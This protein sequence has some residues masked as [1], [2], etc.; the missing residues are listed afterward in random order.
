[1]RKRENTCPASAHRDSNFELLRIIAMVLIVAHHYVV[2]SGLNFADGPIWQAP[3]TVRSLFLLLYGAWGKTAI[4]CFVLITGYFMCKSRITV[5][6]YLKLLL[7]VEFYNLLFYFLFCI[8]GYTEFSL[9]SFAKTILPVVRVDRDFT[10]AYLVFFLCIPFL[11]LL[12]ANMTE[13]M[14][15]RLLILLLFLYTF[16]GSLPVFFVTM[17]Y[18]SWFAVLYLLAAYVRCYP[19]A[20]FQNTKLWGWMAALSLLFSC[21]SIVVCTWLE[22]RFG[23]GTAVDMDLSYY[24]VTDSNAVLAV[25]TGFSVFMFF[26]NLSLPYSHRI[27]TIAASTFGV[28]CIHSNSDAMRFFLWRD[29]FD[30]VGTYGKPWMLLHALLSVC[31]VFI[32]CTALDMLRIK[33]LEGPFFRMYDKKQAHFTHR[34]KEMEEA[35]CRRFSIDPS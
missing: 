31:L 17:N 12:I 35:L 19:K 33:F 15:L 24:F 2:N 10:S 18:V 20:I 8:A 11:N 7:E 16:L 25:L 26:K 30:C 29:L 3:M 34:F 6:K 23:L 5:R 21:A 4:N 27:N 14:H 22:A 1:M 28:L 32:A 13:K 9:L